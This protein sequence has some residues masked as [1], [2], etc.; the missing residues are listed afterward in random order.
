MKMITQENIRK[1]EFLAYISLLIASKTIL[2]NEIPPYLP[3]IFFD[4]YIWDSILMGYSERLSQEHKEMKEIYS[5]IIKNTTKLYK[6]VDMNNPVSIFAT[7]IYMYRSGL[8]S[9]NKEFRYN[10]D[11]KD[12]ANLNG[13]DVIRGK[14][15]CRSISS[16]LTD[17]YKEMDFNSNNLCVHMT[18]GGGIKLNP[19]ELVADEINYDNL[20]LKIIS[21]GKLFANHQINMVQHDNYNYILD[22][23]NDFFLINNNNKLMLNDNNYMTIDNFFNCFQKVF[24]GLTNQYSFLT[25]KKKLSMNT[26]SREEYKVLYLKAIDFCLKNKLLLEDFFL[27]NVNLINDIYAISEEQ[28]NLIKRKL[29][30]LP[31][32]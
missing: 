15:V 2:N 26:I 32:K 27:N 12:F 19:I 29:A 31:R 10:F 20:I 24:N 13:I 3:K 1:G 18:N 21:N 4:I 30:I 5:E 9:Y 14:G 7:Y 22:P 17:I 8:F 23:T 6:D 28:H 11:M 25:D 16:M